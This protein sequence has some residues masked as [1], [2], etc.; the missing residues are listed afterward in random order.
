MTDRLGRLGLKAMPLSDTLDALERLMSSDAVQVGA[1]VEWKGLLR[2]T[3]MHASARYSA[4]LGTGGS[5]TVT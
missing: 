2:A 4:L 5:K 3:G 1:E